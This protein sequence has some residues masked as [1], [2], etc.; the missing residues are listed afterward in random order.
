MRGGA[1]ILSAGGTGLLVRAAA[2]ESRPHVLT[3][4]L[5]RCGR[6]PSRIRRCAAMPVP[7]VQRQLAGRRHL[8]FEGDLTPTPLSRTYTVAVTYNLTCR[9]IVAVLAPPAVLR[10]PQEE[11]PHTFEHD[12]LCLHLNGEWVPTMLLATTTVPWAVEWLLHYEIWLAT[13]GTWCGGGH[14]APER[15][16]R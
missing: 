10:P 5:T 1:G 9:P 4:K 15:S 7:G 6:S 12:V 16:G 13:G 2:L 3:E 11:L 8:R 14:Q